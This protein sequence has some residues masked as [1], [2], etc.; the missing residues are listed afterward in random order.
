MQSNIPRAAIHVGKDKKSFSAQVGNEAERRG[1]DENVYR[2]KNADKEKN[3]HYNFSRKNL[4]FEIVKDGKIVP[5]GSNPIP[6]HERIQMRLDELG[7]KPYMDAR[8]PDQVS[9]NSPNCTVGMIFSGDHD[10][11]YNLAF[12]NQRIDTANPDAD[13]SHIVLQQGIYKWAKDTYDFACCKWGEDNIISFAVHCDETSIHAHVQTIPVE[14]VKKRGRI[15]SK[16]VNKNNPDIVLSTKE[17]RA[18][19][20]EERDNYTKQTASKDYVECVSY[21]EV[22]GET[23][24]AKSEYLSQLHTDYHNEVGCKYGLARGIP[25]NELS[26]EEK[27]GRRHKNKVVLEAERQ[28][29]AALDK[30]EKYA[31]LATIDKQ[32]LT[33]PLLNI[34]TPV[35]EAMDA[36]KQELAI[37][38]PA[39]IGQKTWREE[40]TTNINDAIKALVTAIN[41]ERDKQNYGIRASVN[42]TYT[43]YMQQLNKLIIENKALQNEN[44]TLKAENTE[45]KQRISQLDENAVRRVTAQKDAVI[46][47]L[48][49]HLVSKNEDITRLKTDYNTLWEKYKILVIQWNDLTKQPE[50][51]EAVKR[52]E[53]RKEQEAEA[54]HEEQARQDRYQGVLDRFI[55]EG[56]EQL[57]AF[58]QSSRIDFE[59]KEAKAIYYGIMATAT[60]SNITL[61]SPQG[62]KFAVERFLA[63]MDWNGCGNYRRECVA[64][65]T[66]LFA[67]DEVV[68]TEPIIQNFLS[69]INHMSCSADTYVSLGGSNGCADQLTNWD[70]TQK[71]GLGASPKKKP[72]GLSR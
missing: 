23:R 24:K 56:H 21:A 54:K 32:E 57:K 2:L 37:P 65:W 39:L 5:L 14:K 49:T 62:A 28:A 70:G 22:W 8:H 64:H 6:L 71:L 66:K 44:D 1:W 30:V 15:G 48:N 67:T 34:K 10:M 46:E 36:V 25:Y 41:V 12:G 31:V 45:V 61:C 16:Y 11:L 52:V 42:K 60:K 69:F 3:N 55:S 68:Y 4:N 17:W 47:S 29:K 63:S 58:S 72:Q 20:K 33:F 27:R 26:E 18:L 59:E 7:F 38:I 53:E 40:R 9:K 43:Y 13:H 19:P 35:Q 51:I 50:I